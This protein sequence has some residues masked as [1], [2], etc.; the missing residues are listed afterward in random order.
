MPS[1]LIVDDETALLKSLTFALEEEGFTV[2]GAATAGEGLAEALRLKPDLMLL[3]LRLPD[4]SGLDLLERWPAGEP[5]PQTIM[6]S[7]HGDTRA[8]V[9]AVKMGANDYLTKPFDLDELLHCIHTA[10]ERTRMACEIDFHRQEALRNTGIVGASP[11]IDALGQTI[12]R[13]A[14]S[15]ATRI[16]VLGE[17]GTGKTLVAKA[18]HSG[19]PRA[20]G[21]FIEINCASLPEQLIEAEL[22][23]A[24]KGAYTGAH[25]RRVGLVALADQGTLFLDEIGELPLALQAKLLHFLENGTYRPVGGGRSQT[26]DVRVIAATNRDLAGEVQDGRFREDLFYRLNVITLTVPPLRERG[27]DILHLAQ[28]CAHQ[29]AAEEHVTPIRFGEESAALMRAYAWPGNVRQ[30]KN[31]V[32]RLTILHPGQTITRAHLPAEILRDAST[33][34]PGGSGAGIPPGAATPSPAPGGKVG[35]G[36]ISET[37]NLTEREIILAALQATGGHKGRAA[38]RLGISRHAFKRRLQRLGIE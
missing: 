16:L 5:R 10:L 37:L 32:E 20:G 15:G 30:L 11:A 6:I 29:C 21:P 2:Y 27:D 35:G 26:A 7:A 38:D 22:F 31:L 34:P 28:H 23:G 19:S 17:S 25:Q 14:A 24:E 13:V 3:D 8:A 18:I 33:P 12:Q 9:R 36:S 4:M 1:L